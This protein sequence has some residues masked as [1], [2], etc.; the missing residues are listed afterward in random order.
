MKSW[1]KRIVGAALM[2]GVLGLLVSACADN[3]SSVFIRQVL[4]PTTGTCTYGAD[5]SS[6]AYTEGTLDLAFRSEYTAG[7]LVGSQLVE[8]GSSQ[9]IRTE[10]SRLRIEGSEVRIE[11]TDGSVLKEYTV[12]TSGF[13]DP[14]SGTTPGWGVVSSVLID[15]ATGDALRSSPSL[16]AAPGQRSTT[17]MRVV[18]VVK[19]FGTTLGGQKETSGEFRFPIS[20]CYGCLVSFPPDA[21]DSTLPLP[22]CMATGSTTGT[23]VSEPCYLGQDSAVDCRTCTNSGFPTGICQP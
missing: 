12:P 7:L 14:A 23:S 11:T 4:Q 13:V 8:R 3:E 15:S 22:N 16:V 9:Q 1:T 2:S 20:V 5:P 21:A 6:M 10:T 17:I 19:V 18:S